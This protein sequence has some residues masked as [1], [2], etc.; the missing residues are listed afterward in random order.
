MARYRKLIIAM[1]LILPVAFICGCEYGKVDQGRV[2]KIDMDKGIVTLIRDVKNDQQNPEYAYLPALSYS[3]PKN[4]AEMG[5]EPKAGMRMKLVC[6]EERD[7]DLRHGHSEIQDH[8]VHADR[9]E[10]NVAKDD[11]LVYDASQQKAK[12]FPA[13]DKEKKTISITPEGRKFDHFLR[14]PTST[15][16]FRLHVG[17]RRRSRIYLQG[18]RKSLR[19]MNNQQGPYIFQE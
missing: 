5:A 7:H 14:C 9:A 18:R 8:T 15:S 19:F 1:L 17:R 12:K 3:L 10:K 16:A 11:P 2:I 6:H 13:I 4:P